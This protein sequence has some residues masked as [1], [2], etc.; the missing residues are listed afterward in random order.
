LASPKDE[1]LRVQ[2]HAARYAEAEISLGLRRA[3]GTIPSIRSGSMDPGVPLPPHWKSK[4]G[5]SDGVLRIA[6]PEEAAVSYRVQ[7]AEVAQLTHDETPLQTDAGAAV[8]TKSHLEV[9]AQ[10]IQD[11][12][13]T[14][15]DDAAVPLILWEEGLFRKLP[16]WTHA[17]GAELR[18]P[19]GNLNFRGACEILKR[20]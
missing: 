2:V 7:C 17:A 8:R 18:D 10:A 12:K 14:K 11:Q 20:C 3:D 16:Q 15:S 13:A 6:S 19:T 9:V 5:V 1:E 4:G